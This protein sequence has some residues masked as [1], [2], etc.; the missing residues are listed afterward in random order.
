MPTQDDI[1]TLRLEGRVPFSHFATAINALDGLLKSL[2]TEI[3]GSPATVQWNIVELSASSAVTT[4]QGT[5]DD[6]MDIPPITTAYA[7]VGQALADRSEIPYSEEIRRHAASIAS[8]VN[9]E[10]TAIHFNTPRAQYVV[11]EPPER[12]EKPVVVD[13]FGAIEGHIRTLSDRQNLRFTLY[14]NLFDAPVTCYLSPE[15]ADEARRLWRQRVVVEGLVRRD[16][17]TGIPTQIRNIRE[18]HEMPSAAP[19]S[20]REARGAL[21]NVVGS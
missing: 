7:L 14:D 6:P 12:Q 3:T 4:I 5:A 1:V 13:G 19:G 2:S 18:I 8:L 15:T 11:R 20:Y 16:P 9:G 21:R 17:K 10:I